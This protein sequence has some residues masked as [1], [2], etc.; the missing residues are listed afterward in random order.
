VIANMVSSPH[1]LG[2]TMNT[3]RRH[4]MTD[5]FGRLKPGE[6]LESA[7][8]ELTAIHAAIVKE[9]REAYSKRANVQLRVAR[10]REQIAAP[11]RTILLVLLSAAGIVF[12]IACS[13]CRQS[14]CGSLGP[15]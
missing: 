4:R 3:D 12:V 8:A 7:R 5:L 10:L 14:D 13:S 6:S 2:A 9:H 11:A 1:H 15:A